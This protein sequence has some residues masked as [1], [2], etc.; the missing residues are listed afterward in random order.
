LYFPNVSPPTSSPPPSRVPRKSFL[1]LGSV[2]QPLPPQVGA[3]LYLHVAP[4]DLFTVSPQRSIAK[5]YGKHQPNPKSVPFSRPNTAQPPRLW[6][7]GPFFLGAPLLVFPLFIFIFG[8]KPSYFFFLLPLVKTLLS[9]LCLGFFPSSHFLFPRKLLSPP[10]QP[11]F[12]CGIDPLF[13]ISFQ[14]INGG[15]YPRF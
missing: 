10:R 9:H 11:P 13:F 1:Q 4:Y 15:T 6:L 8:K 7:I 14:T 12:P 5:P 3:P 2:F